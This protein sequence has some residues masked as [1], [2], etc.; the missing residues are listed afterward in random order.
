MTKKVIRVNIRI[1]AEAVQRRLRCQRRCTRE[2]CVGFWLWYHDAA[3]RPSRLELRADG[4]VSWAGRPPE[5]EWHTVGDE[6]HAT[7]NR[8]AHALRFETKDSLVLTWPSRN[9]PSRMRR[10]V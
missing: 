7:F 1:L 2:G 3:A 9:P 8:T 4:T 5:G 10:A 6:L